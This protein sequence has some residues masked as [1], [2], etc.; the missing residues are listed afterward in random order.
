MIAGRDELEPLLSDEL[1][2]AKRFEVVRPAP[3]EL[4]SRTGRP[5]WTGEEALPQ[6][7]LASLREMYGCD[8]VLFCRLTVFRPYG[9]L[10]VGWRMK[11]VETGS[12]RIL[13]AADEVFDNGEPAVRE[14]ARQFQRHRDEPK[15]RADGWVAWTSPRAFG[16]FSLAQL[17][18]TLPDSA[19]FEDIENFEPPAQAANDGDM[20]AIFKEHLRRAGY[21]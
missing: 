19:T 3:E 21:P 7:L 12:G 15:E 10:A 1:I 17:F 8:A 9:T 4:E 16:Q 14:T 2:K 6:H 13:W 11:L 5:T 20:T 18:A